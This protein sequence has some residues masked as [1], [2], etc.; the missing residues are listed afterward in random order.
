L[1]TKTFLSVTFACVLVTLA[2]AAFATDIIP[3]A[4]GNKWEYDCYKVF[5]GDVRFQGKSVGSN[6]DASF[7]TSV[8]EVLAVDNKSA[9]PV[10]DYRETTQTK[11]STGG[12]DSTETLDLKLINDNEGQKVI[13][14]SQE[15]T[16]D[17]KPDKQTYDPPIFYYKH[18]CAPG[19]QWNV[20]VMRDTDTRIPLIAKVVGKETI[21][22]PAGT[23]KDCLKVA[24]TS[25]DISGTVD[26]WEKQ[27]TITSGK[28]RGI[29]WV[30]DGVGVVKELEVS[31]SVAETKG[32]DGTP[33]SVS[34]A[35]CVV[36][37]LRPGY[38]IKK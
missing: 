18:N 5:K 26:M 34:T 25:D 19:Q 1:K 14:T 37:E 10:Y 33:V 4:V 29:Y 28:S 13:W 21:T 35:T 30:A 3:C 15:A 20:G 24:Y 7:G 38:I 8:Y 27:F 11:S 22:V 16:G 36:S 6:N 32:P 17:D 2:A 31:T 9:Q 12:G 23:F